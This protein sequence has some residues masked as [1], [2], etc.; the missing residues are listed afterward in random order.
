M[1]GTQIWCKNGTP[2]YLTSCSTLPYIKIQNSKSMFPSFPLNSFKVNFP[3]G[4]GTLCLSVGQFKTEDLSQTSIAL[5]T[6]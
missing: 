3:K 4:T 2:R 5:N 1:R 6:A